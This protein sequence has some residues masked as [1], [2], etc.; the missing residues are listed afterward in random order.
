VAAASEQ[1]R[2]FRAHTLAKYVALVGL[3]L[4]TTLIVGPMVLPRLGHWLSSMG[5]ISGATAERM[6]WGPIALFGTAIPGSTAFLVGS[7]AL[8]IAVGLRVRAHFRCTSK[9][10]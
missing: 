4:G 2:H 1:A 10:E 5:V 3:G 7:V 6:A 9:R 8:L